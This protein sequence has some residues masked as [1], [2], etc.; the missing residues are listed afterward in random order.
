[1]RRA[2]T[3][4]VL[5]ALA[6]APAWSWGF[7]GHRIVVESACA[8]LPSPLREFFEAA[9]T[10]VSDAAIEPDSVLKER[11]GEVEKRRHYINLELL[12]AAP[13][14]DIPA[15]EQE[16]VSRYG[17]R[18]LE[19][20]GLLPWHIVH[21]QQ[22]LRAAFQSGSWNEV[23]RQAGWLSHYV[24]DAFQPLHATVNHDGQRTCNQGIHTA[25][26]T[27]LIDRFKADYKAGSAPAEGVDLSPVDDPAT[28]MLQEL[29]AS[30]ALV[31]DLLRADT[32]AVKAVKSGRGD[33]FEE[34]ERLA[35][36]MARAQ[37]RKAA[38]TVARLWH[39]AWVEAGRPDPPAR[40]PRTRP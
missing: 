27:D 36:P 25:F 20:A 39:T 18:K 7:V 22:S 17:R 11:D 9:R 31:A 35:G 26:E 1:M 23:V 29:R 5:M 16:A 38:A 30:H 33:Y 14:T 34:M 28:L 37:M 19:D 8:A 24:A 32:K 13:F 15:S 4:I 21:V 12:A 3:A 2:W 40:P 10:R 6:A